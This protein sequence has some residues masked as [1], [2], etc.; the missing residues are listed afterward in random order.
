MPESGGPIPDL[1]RLLEELVDG[2]LTPA[3]RLRLMGLLRGDRASLE[4]SADYLLLDSMLAWE[5]SRSGKVSGDDWLALRDGVAP[6]RPARSRHVGLRTLAGLAAI[7]LVAIVLGWRAGTSP[8]GP[9]F[10]TNAKPRPTPSEPR[11]GDEIDARAVA[12]LSRAINPVWGATSL[13]TEVGS[14]LPPGRLVLQSGLIQVEFF[15]GALVILEG[16]ADFELLSADRASCRRGRLMVRAP[17]QSS[18]FSVVTPR[19]DVIDLGT[20]FGVR[21]DE[22][23]GSEVQVFE[24]SIELQGGRAAELPAAGRKLISGQAVRIDESGV[25]AI[26]RADAGVYVGARE[27]DARSLADSGVRY[28]AWLDQ[29]RRLQADP[30][31]RLYYSFEGQQG[32]ERSLRDRA[33]DPGP[34][35]DGSIVGCRWAE[36]RWPGKASLDFKRPSDRVRL[37]VPGEFKA[38]TL[39]VWVRVDDFDHRLNSLILSDGWNLRGQVHWELD[40]KGRL[41]FALKANGVR[42]DSPVVLGPDQLGLWNHLVTVFDPRHGTAASFVNGRE[43]ARQKVPVESR[44]SI[45]WADLGNWSYP[46]P[47]DPANAP[48][49]NLNGRIDEFVVFDQALDADEVRALYEVG[50]PG[51]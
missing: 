38:L 41:I 27:L 8:R 40:G 21:V 14:G 19:A 4:A 36:G 13:P 28:R 34:G 24:G 43:V 6:P 20:E 30:R 47:K 31:V 12:V 2:D 17:V 25:S 37:Y 11:G 29:S 16:P 7:V 1:E 22:A 50:K 44:A 42:C 5:G 51:T 48:V 15:G 3:E 32:W 26:S 45:G 10:A 39:A 23:G 46:E 49:R 9:E 33:A 35:F 18:H